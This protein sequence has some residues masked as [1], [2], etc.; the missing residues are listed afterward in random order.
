M[1][2][3]TRSWL[4]Y[5]FSTPP[6]RSAVSL[7][8]LY[9]GVLLAALEHEVLEEVGHPVLLGSL[10]ARARVERDEY[11]QRPRAR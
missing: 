3:A 11:G 8:S 9:V 4:V 10:V 6:S 5:A 1:W 7:T 2:K